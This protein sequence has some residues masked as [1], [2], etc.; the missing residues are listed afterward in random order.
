MRPISAL[1]AAWRLSDERPPVLATT[2]ANG[3]TISLMRWPDFFLLEVKAEGDGIR[4]LYAIESL[5]EAWAAYHECIEPAQLE[6]SRARGPSA[7][8]IDFPTARM[9]RRL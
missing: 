7:L 3:R 8:I 9:A 1:E 4:D 5:Q 6:R 2:Q